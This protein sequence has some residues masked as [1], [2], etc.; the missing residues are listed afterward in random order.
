V[1]GRGVSAAAYRQYIRA[2]KV[3]ERATG[4]PGTRPF[5]TLTLPPPYCLFDLVFVSACDARVFVCV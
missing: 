4:T 1:R 3:C 2:G 5:T